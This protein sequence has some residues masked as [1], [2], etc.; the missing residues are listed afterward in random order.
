VADDENRKRLCGDEAMSQFGSGLAGARVIVDLE[1]D[2]PASTT[3]MR[4]DVGDQPIKTL[5]NCG[6]ERAPWP[7]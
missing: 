6:A 4:L 5:A 3:S 1:I 7:R 2:R